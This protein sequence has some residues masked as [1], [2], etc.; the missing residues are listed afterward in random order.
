MTSDGLV[1]TAQ[2]LVGGGRGLLAIDES[3]PTCNTRFADAGIDQTEE[4][5]RRY[6]EL[7]ITTPHLAECISG[8]ILH[9]ETIRQGKRDG[10][11]FLQVLADA[12]IIPGIKVDTGARPLALHPSEMVTEGLDGLRG[13]LQEY[14][15]LGARF[16]KWRAV[17]PVGV[18][19]PT[20]C[21][22]EANAHAL[23]RY[24]ALCQ[25]ANLVPVIEPEVL[26]TGTHTMARCGE[27]TRHVLCSVFEQMHRQGVRLDGLV[28]KVNMVLPGLD[29]PPAEPVTMQEVADATLACLLEMVPPAVAGIVFLSGGQSCERASA[30][31]NA[32]NRQTAFARARIPWSLGF[33][34]ARAIQQPALHIWGGLEA[35]V[36]AAQQ[37]VSHRAACNRAALRGDYDAAMEQPGY[38]T[39]GS[40]RVK[41]QAH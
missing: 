10:T 6:R 12:G 30:R 19:S 15:A 38:G 39:P 21:G 28:L 4:T 32:L 5:R 23:G 13:R 20:A 34:Y 2:A 9:D 31:L 36:G 29:S 25:E 24:A 14:S 11:S 18:R 33:S 26:M 7:L 22:V 35:N 37:A 16:A 27:I 40:V 1:A 17:F 3:V 8:V 41:Q